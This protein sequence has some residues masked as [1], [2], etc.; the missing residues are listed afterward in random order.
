MMNVRT[1]LAPAQYTG[2]TIRADMDQDIRDIVVLTIAICKEEVEKSIGSTIE[3]VDDG[4]PWGRAFVKACHV[5][6][7]LDSANPAEPRPK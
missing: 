2:E 3:M 6:S 4:S 1:G 7:D 5:L